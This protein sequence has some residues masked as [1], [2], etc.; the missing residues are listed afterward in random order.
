MVSLGTDS[1]TEPNLRGPG[2]TNFDFSLMRNQLIRERFNVQFRAEAFNLFNTPQ[3][4]QPDS[5]V[6]S[7]IF[8]R[9]LGGGSDRVL[10]LGLRLSF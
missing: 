7:P 9:I 4:D 5:S 8:G 1:R 3:W 2:I 10:Q 6:N